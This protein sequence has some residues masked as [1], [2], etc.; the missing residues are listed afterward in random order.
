MGSFFREA[1]YNLRKSAV[2]FIPPARATTYATNSAPF[3]GTL[4]WN[5]LPSSIKASKSITEFQTNL[6]IFGNIDCG[7]FISRK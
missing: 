5:R 1:P 3:R 7:C 4:I 6:K 2:F